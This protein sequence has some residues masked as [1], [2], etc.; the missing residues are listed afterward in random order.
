MKSGNKDKAKRILKTVKMERDQLINLQNKATL[1]S[2]QVVQ[3]ESI[4][5]DDGFMSAITDANRVMQG[6]QEKQ[7]QLQEQLELNKE[8]E[9]EAKMNNDMINNM[10]ADSD[11]D[12]LDDELAQYEQMNAMDMAKDFDSAQKD[13]VT[14]QQQHQ[15]AKKHDDI[16]DLF[17]QVLTN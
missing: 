4:Q 10:I 12:E 11:E 15:P 9:N 5:S 2:K 17:N 7:E 16:D 1:L 14:P 13:I 6:N 3:I 8:M